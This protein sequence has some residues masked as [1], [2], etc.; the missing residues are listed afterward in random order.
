MLFSQMFECVFSVDRFVR[1][2]VVVHMD[3]HKVACVV[4]KH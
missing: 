1:R 2:E 3:V 4:H